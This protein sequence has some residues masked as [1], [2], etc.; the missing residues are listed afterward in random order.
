MKIRRIKRNNKNKMQPATNTGLEDIK[1]IYGAISLQKT[2]KQA[3]RPIM[4]LQK[5]LEL[6]QN[7]L[8]SMTGQMNMN[9]KMR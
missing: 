8:R 3:N 1:V 6:M 4:I 7:C 2:S 5:R 9:I